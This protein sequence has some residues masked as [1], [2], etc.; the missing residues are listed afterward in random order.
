MKTPQEKIEELTEAAKPLIKYLN[1]NH[2]PHV[3]AIVTTDSVEVVE[4]V[5]SNPNIK[6]FIKD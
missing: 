1:E 4:G 6:D 3:K 5:L 2:N